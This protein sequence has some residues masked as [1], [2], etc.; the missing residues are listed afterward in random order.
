MVSPEVVGYKML[1]A[2]HFPPDRGEDE[3]GLQR[4]AEP[5]G[6]GEA[7]RER[8]GT[9]KGRTEWIRG[10]SLL[11]QKLDCDGRPLSLESADPGSS[12]QNP[13]LT[14]RQGKASLSSTG[15]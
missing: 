14:P 1:A 15:C 8:G 11:L 10:P 7:E 2:S 5:R 6:L 3:A 12:Y 4:D 9:L 13:F